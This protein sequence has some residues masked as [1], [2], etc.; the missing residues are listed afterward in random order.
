[1]IAVGSGSRGDVM[2]G[3]LGLFCLF[4]AA[5][6]LGC[7][8]RDDN[9][10]CVD[11]PA[12]SRGDICGVGAPLTHSHRALAELA[13][14]L[15]ATDYSP[16]EQPSVRSVLADLIRAGDVR[17][18]E[19]LGVALRTEDQVRRWVDDCE[20]ALFRHP[21]LAA[22]M[23]RVAAVRPPDLILAGRRR[24]GLDE[25]MLVL[26]DRKAPVLQRWDAANAFMACGRPEH[27][28]KLESLWD[29]ATIYTWSQVG[30]PH[31]LDETIAGL[32]MRCVEAIRARHQR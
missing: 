25:A 5:V 31:S 11:A 1:M 21:E 4:L 24:G 29:D 14:R 26:L 17:G 20:R 8:R 15:P 10:G 7:G 2:H 13:P 27:I 22:A 12:T 18:I 30:N 16:A 28:P 3:R 23:E 9:V 19:V 6:S 32:S